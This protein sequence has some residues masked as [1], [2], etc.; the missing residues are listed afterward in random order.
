M[1]LY[2][3]DRRRILIVAPHCRFVQTLIS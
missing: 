2:V 1:R 3:E